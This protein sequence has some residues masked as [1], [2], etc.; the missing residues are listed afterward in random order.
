MDASGATAFTPSAIAVLIA[1]PI[2]LNPLEK[3][4]S[5]PVEL[6]ALYSLTSSF[7]PALALGR[8]F[9]NMLSNF[10]VLPLLAA[11][12]NAFLAFVTFSLPLTRFLA[13][14]DTALPIDDN[15]PMFISLYSPFVYIKYL[16]F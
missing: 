10:F 4:L 16:S 11:P 1:L 13:A 12:Y 15:S 9:V 7:I 3:L 6:V 2:P 14:K 5:I 8:K